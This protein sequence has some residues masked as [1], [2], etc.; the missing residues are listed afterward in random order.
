MNIKYSIVLLLFPR[1][2]VAETLSVPVQFANK[3]VFYMQKKHLQDINS[4]YGA[5]FDACNVE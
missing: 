5:L 3:P 4:C 1:M 2:M